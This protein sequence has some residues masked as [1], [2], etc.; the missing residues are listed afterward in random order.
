MWERL[1]PRRWQR[2]TETERLLNCLH[3]A[4]SRW[5]SNNLNKPRVPASCRWLPAL[6]PALLTLRPLD[7]APVWEPRQLGPS[8][9]PATPRRSHARPLPAAPTSRRCS[10]S[11]ATR[12]RLLPVPSQ[13]LGTGRPGAAGS[14]GPASPCLAARLRGS[15][16]RQLCP[17]GRPRARPGP[18]AGF[19][20]AGRGGARTRRRLRGGR[21]LC[22]DLC[23][24]A[25][26]RGAQERPRHSLW[27]P[28]PLSLWPSCS[29]WSP[30]LRGTPLEAG[31]LVQ[32]KAFHSPT[33]GE[34]ETEMTLGF[35]QLRCPWHF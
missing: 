30:R 4:Y 23:A 32:V 2:S 15:C 26:L 22:S 35:L 6:C 27:A 5:H 25:C 33:P 7:L 14:R 24:T 31:K 34:E 11:P 28:R 12:A 10:W 21:G 8:Q 18:S 19:R 29:L 20:G 1:Q 16:N 13:A 3:N 9:A 17:P